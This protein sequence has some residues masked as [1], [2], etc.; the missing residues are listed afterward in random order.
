MRF[1][2]KILTMATCAV[3]AASSM[4]GMSA[5]AAISGTTST[6]AVTPELMTEINAWADSLY[7][8]SINGTFAR[9]ISYSSDWYS[10]LGDVEILTRLI[11][12]ET[13]TNSSYYSNEHRAVA[14][15]LIN[16]VNDGRFGGSTFRSVATAY[17]QFETIRGYSGNTQS[18]NIERTKNA[19][20]PD[21]ST[22]AS[23]AAWKDAIWLACTLLS[24]SSPSDCSSIFNKPTG[25]TN[26]LYFSGSNYVTFG[27]DSSGGLTISGSSVSNAAYA[28]YGVVTTE[29]AAEANASTHRNIYYYK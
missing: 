14:W 21:L 4:V 24:V 10:D 22:S 9:A 16:R 26:Q 5:S 6:Y 20:E 19:R 13:T 23:K 25:I 29:S 17:D 28:G 18:Q 1:T 2:K 3:M 12:A 27:T 8:A 7:T 15:V 11:Y